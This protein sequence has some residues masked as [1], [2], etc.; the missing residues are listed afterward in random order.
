LRE[1]DSSL[2][3]CPPQAGWRVQ[4]DKLSYFVVNKTVMGN[5]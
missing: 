1:R 5:I 4:N 3:S 2:A